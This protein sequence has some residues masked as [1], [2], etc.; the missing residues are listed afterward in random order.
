M[1]LA[2][3]CGSSSPMLASVSFTWATCSSSATLAPAASSTSSMKA[4]SASGSL[5][6]ALSTSSAATLPDP[7]QIELSGESR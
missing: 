4:G 1:R 6:I 3:N 2:V 7:S 5:T